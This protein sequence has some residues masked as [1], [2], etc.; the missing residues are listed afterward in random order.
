MRQSPV[1]NS[2]T[3]SFTVYIRVDN[4]EGRL[5]AGQFAEGDLI[6]HALENTHWLPPSAI[7]DRHSGAPYV[8]TVLDGHVLRQAVRLSLVNESEQ[9]VAVSDIP[10][11]A[12]VILAN[13]LGVQAG[14]RV[15]VNRAQ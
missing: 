10:L 5:R 6:I 12:T 8:L 11:G 2:G 7:R 1:A 13:V 14:D 9:R 4:H 3:R 15:Q